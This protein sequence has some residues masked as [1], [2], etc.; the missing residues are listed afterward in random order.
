MISVADPIGR[1]VQG[2]GTLVSLASRVYLPTQVDAGVE[3]HP[4]A[5]S[6][7]AEMGPGD[8]GGAPGTGPG[9]D[10]VRPVV[11]ASGCARACLQCPD[12]GVWSFDPNSPFRDVYTVNWQPIPNWAGPL[13]LAGLVAILPAWVADRIMTSLTLGW[14]RRGHLSGCGG[15]WPA[16][17]ACMSRPCWPRFRHEHGLAVRLYQLH[18]RRLPVPDHARALVAGPRPF[19]RA[20]SA[21]LA[22]L[23]TLGYFCHLVS[24]GL[25]IV[26][27]VV[28]SR[29]GPVS[30][31]G[32]AAGANGSPAWRERARPS[33]PSSFWDY[34]ICRSRPNG[35]RCAR[36]GA[37]C[38]IPGHPG[39]GSHGSSGLIPFR[40]RSETGCH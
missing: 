31:D 3:A 5:I 37:T 10:L 40:W 4:V 6:G 7:R 25:T 2:D 15:E 26:G 14:L 21:A 9:R 22:L 18:A 8:T 24:L 27:L 30:N 33:F 17:A 29:G 11:R 36:Y 38:P 28:L 12:P 23:L 34:A 20:S 19:E 39:P 16:R 1:P 13:T 32:E 35:L